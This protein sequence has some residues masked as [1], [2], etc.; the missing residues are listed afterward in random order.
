MFTVPSD[1]GRGREGRQLYSLAWSSSL[2]KDRNSCGIDPSHASAVESSKSYAN[3]FPV[4]S[5]F[6]ALR[7]IPPMEEIPTSPLAAAAGLYLIP[8]LIFL[9]SRR[10]VATSLSIRCSFTLDSGWAPM[11]E[12]KRC[13]S[14]TRRRGVI[15]RPPY[16]CG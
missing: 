5:L 12:E 3:P 10:S 16:P 2:P 4:P 8:L 11:E 9:I 7:P 13:R 14:E 1:G 6:P 15:G